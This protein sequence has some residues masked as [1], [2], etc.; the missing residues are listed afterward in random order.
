MPLRYRCEWP[1]SWAV[2]HRGHSIFRLSLLPY[3]LEFPVGVAGLHPSGRVDTR[4]VNAV[5]RHCPSSAGGVRCLVAEVD[6]WRR[7]FRV[8]HVLRP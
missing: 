5:M 8:S 4:R 3:H 2:P 1:A 7:P 6:I